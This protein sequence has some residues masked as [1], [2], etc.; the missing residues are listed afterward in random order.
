[1]QVRWAHLESQCYDF[2]ETVDQRLNVII[3]DGVLEGAVE[4]VAKRDRRNQDSA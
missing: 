2:P 1:M 3:E 4:S